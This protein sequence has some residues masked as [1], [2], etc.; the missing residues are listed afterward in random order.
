MHANPSEEPLQ[1]SK[2]FQLSRMANKRQ[3]KESSKQFF[4]VSH[5]IL[6]IRCPLFICL[7]AVHF[8]AR[9]H[10]IGNVY[11]I[12]VCFLCPFFILFAVKYKK[13]H[14]VKCLTRQFSWGHCAIAFRSSKCFGICGLMF[15]HHLLIRFIPLIFSLPRCAWWFISFTQCHRLKGQ[16]VLFIESSVFTLLIIFV[17]L[18][19][20]FDCSA[21]GSRVHHN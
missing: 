9:I 1:S 11:V 20:R 10:W 16:P 7:L 14:F 17:E 3:W 19:A 13:C 5:H 6:H 4:L 15:F 12:S 2:L 18:Y 8:F 21:S